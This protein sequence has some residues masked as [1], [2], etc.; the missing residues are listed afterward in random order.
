MKYTAPSFTVPASGKA[1]ENCLHGWIDKRD[2]C[3]MC[4]T[5]VLVGLSQEIANGPNGPDRDGNYIA[6]LEP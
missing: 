1:P 3:V 6:Y 5:R 4:G 2:R